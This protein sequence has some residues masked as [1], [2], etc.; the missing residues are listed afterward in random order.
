MKT[1][2]II[3]ISIFV[4]DAYAN[5][6]SHTKSELSS[7]FQFAQKTSNA[8]DAIADAFANQQSN[9]QVSGRGRVIKIL[10]DDNDG[11][12]HQR[13]ILSLS[14]GQTLLVAHNIDLAPRINSLKMGDTI[15][16]Y[17]EYE[18]NNKGGV[19]HWTHHDPDGFHEGGWLKHRGKTYQ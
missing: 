1:A 15:E 12:R 14:S 17:G 10:S 2:L 13:F 7:I 19:I 11:S 6:F 3:L 18:W 5:N 8:Q 9:V 4:S 16:F